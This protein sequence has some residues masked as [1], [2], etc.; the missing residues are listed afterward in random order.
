MNIGIVT[1]W[2]ERGAAYVSKQYADLLQKDFNVFIYAR[3]GEMYAIGDKKWDKNN[4][5]WGKKSNIPFIAALDLSD[6]KK[7]LITNKI[8]VV[9]FNEQYWLQPV[10]LAKKMGIKTGAYVD[11]YTKESI[12]LFV[13]YDFLI[14]NTKRHYQAFKWHPQ[15][16][17]VPWGTDIDLFKPAK[18]N[19]A[20][21]TFFH[22]AGYNPQ[23]KGT[24]L[25]IK[26]FSSLRGKADLIVH[27][28]APISNFFPELKPVVKEM[29][30]SGDLKIIERSVPAPGLYHLGDV[31][32]YPSRLDGIG[33]TIAEALSCGLPVIISDNPPMNEF[34][35]NDIGSLVK[36]VKLYPRDDRY[37]W[38]QCEVDS[39]DLKRSMLEYL[40]RSNLILKSS[41]AR[42]YAENALN[43][44][45][46]SGLLVKIFKDSS[47]QPINEELIIGDIK[48][49][50]LKNTHYNLYRKSPWLYR[51]VKW[52][53]GIARKL[54]KN[55]IWKGQ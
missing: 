39:D 20:K 3:G 45:A 11:Y 24:D 50:E 16:Y 23:R 33:L 52:A 22:S 46:N 48:K 1:T 36:I 26:A 40:N 10:I 43:W 44:K 31:Y 8:D 28:Q 49:F 4:V 34:V 54:T 9:F 12:P 15:A 47:I 2:F 32:V 51:F 35:N 7:W 30:A 18:S 27:T 6:F 21:L 38:P 14:C 37:Y 29:S 17:Y 5:T 19:N 42:K 55:N 53:Y 25:V 13:I 41:N